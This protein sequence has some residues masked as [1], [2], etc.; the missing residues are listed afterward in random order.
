MLPVP[1]MIASSGQVA[2]AV[3]VFC[4]CCVLVLDGCGVND[5][6]RCFNKVVI[7]D[8]VFAA[9]AAVVVASAGVVVI[10]CRDDDDDDDDELLQ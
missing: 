7:A 8:V 3:V 10:T 6:L 2:N 4:D 1:P 9:A 5:C